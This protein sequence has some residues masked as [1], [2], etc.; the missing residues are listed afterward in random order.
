MTSGRAAYCWGAVPGQL[1]GVTSPALVTGGLSFATISTGFQ[2]CGVA[3]GGAAYCWGGG[4]GPSPVAVRGGVSFATVSAGGGHTCGVTPSGT[5]YCW[6]D[7]RYGQLGNGT[8]TSS[9]TPTPVAQ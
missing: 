8:R 6:G 5:A 4:D 9:V 3:T 2:I 7:N 1:E